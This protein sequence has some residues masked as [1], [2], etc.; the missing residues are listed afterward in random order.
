MSEKNSNNVKH[1]LW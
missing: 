1:V